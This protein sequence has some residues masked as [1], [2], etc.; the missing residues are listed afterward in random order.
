[1]SRGPGKWQRAV[2]DA[3]EAKPV[4]FPGQRF[5]VLLGRALTRPEDVALRRAVRQLE[6]AGLVET[7]M[8]WSGDKIALAVGKPGAAVDGKPLKELSVARVPSGHTGN[9]YE[10]S[11][12][13]IAQ[14]ERIIAT[15]VRRDLAAAEAMGR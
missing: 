7:A 3:L 2:L 13:N 10:G 8:V 14:R 1:M 15:Q 4:F 12:R 11:L 9:T 6:R 5:R